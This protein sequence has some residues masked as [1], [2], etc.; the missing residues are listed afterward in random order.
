MTNSSPT[1]VLKAAAVREL[2]SRVAFNFDDLRDQAAAQLAAARQEAIDLV[3]QAKKD[4]EALRQKTLAEARES[5]RKEGLKDAGQLIEQQATKLADARLAEHL[6]TTL[7]ALEQAAQ[8]L[9]AERDHWLSRWERAAVE[10][11]IA[12]AEKLLRTNLAAQP[13]L[14]EGMIAEALQLAA[15]QPQ[16]RM[17]WNPA[18]LARLGDRAQQVVQA[19]TSCATPEL[20]ADA[21]IASG[22]CRIETRHGE[23]DARLE[24]MLQRIA[25]EL[26]SP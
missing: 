15:G 17:H 23:I 5:G 22:G 13:E 8:A 20:I 25:E 4:A 24:T 10:L 18:D 6:T 26:L 1:R 16:L 7:P 14:A 21:T 3:D 9:R 19:L 12:I 11:G 2:S